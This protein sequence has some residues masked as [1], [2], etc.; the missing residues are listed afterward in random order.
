M[1]IY[2]FKF[3]PQTQNKLLEFSTTH[4][5]DESDTFRECWTEWLQTN[6]EIVEKE[7][8]YLI[9]K[10]YSGDVKDKMYKSVRYYFKNKPIKKNESTK[11]K[12]YIKISKDMLKAM[13]QHIS[14][15]GIKSKPADSY[16]GFNNLNKELIETEKKK[17]SS[18]LSKDEINLKLK[19]TYKNRYFIKQK[20]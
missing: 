1:S 19:K 9:N 3:S 18:K 7:E 8:R 6:K 10:G 17:L 11:R 20:E 13:D 12:N 14:T 5:Y 4:R 2:R 16:D 15:K